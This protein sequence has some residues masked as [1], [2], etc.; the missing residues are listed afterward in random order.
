[1]GADEE[2]SLSGVFARWDADCVCG[3]LL[4]L[5]KEQRRADMAPV[6]LAFIH[7]GHEILTFSHHFPLYWSWNHFPLWVS[8]EKDIV[9]GKWIIASYYKN[10]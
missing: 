3:G 1:M 5:L 6:K 4:L 9:D 10:I 8:I 7:I 2:V